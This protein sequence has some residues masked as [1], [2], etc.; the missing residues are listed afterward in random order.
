MGVRVDK[1]L[2]VA[3]V[4]KTR[5]KATKAC[6]L[7]RVRVNGVVAKAHR[8]LATGDQ[9]EVRIS[10]WIRVLIVQE[11]RDKPLPKAEAPRLYEDQSPPRPE[12][13]GWERLLHRPPA[14]REPGAG[15]PTKRQRRDIDRWRDR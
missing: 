1:W 8:A 5:S 10:D 4:F 13:K 11:L 6:V 2:Q 7:G 9:V 15:R 14:T 3:R 12:R